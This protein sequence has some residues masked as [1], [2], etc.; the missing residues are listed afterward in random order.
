MHG[1]AK[2]NRNTISF[3]AEEAEEEAGKTGS[4]YLP[5][6]LTKECLVRAKMEDPDKQKERAELVKAMSVHELAQI[7]SISDLPMPA[8]MSR[9]NRPVERKKKFREK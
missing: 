1:N 5:E 3:R 6:S 2:F 9:G 4:K 8:F 7:S